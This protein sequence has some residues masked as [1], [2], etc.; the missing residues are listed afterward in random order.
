[1]KDKLSRCFAVAVFGALVLPFAYW[2]LFFDH[3]SQSWN[4]SCIHHS[5]SQSFNKSLKYISPALREFLN[6]ISAFGLPLTI[7]DLPWLQC[8]GG[9]SGIC[10]QLSL[11]RQFLFGTE[12]YKAFA[13]NITR[14]KPPLWQVSTT[15][16]RITVLIY[17]LRIGIVSVMHR[18][19][20]WLIPAVKEFNLPAYALKRYSVAAFNATSYLHVRYPYPLREFL[21]ELSEAEFIECQ[22][23]KAVA[24]R[25]QYASSNSSIPVINDT[26]IEQLAYFRDL[27]LSLHISPFLFGGTLLGWYRECGIIPHTTDLDMAAFISQFVPQLVSVLKNDQRLTL[28][29]M[30]GKPSDSLELSVFTK[31]TKTTKID[32]FFVYNDA[33]GS[34]V[35][36]MIPYER[37]KL[38]WTY[39]RISRLCKAELLNELFSVPCNVEEV[40]QA[41]YGSNWSIS[42]EE[43]NFLWYK[44]HKNVRTIG[45]YNTYEWM[46]VFRLFVRSKRNV[47]S[48][49]PPTVT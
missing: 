33:N 19:S 6:R 39:P 35:G 7:L 36:G 32:L 41:D 5:Y 15:A 16:A 31:S 47:S 2:N 27:L 43:R 17:N 49:S 45:K 14:I 3:C 1:M 12:A 11:R 13:E 28:Y 37:K 22:H 38:R 23:E 25:R 18:G 20:Y 30:L 34:W 24:I 26:A 42:V 9:V 46:N 29:W 40:L 48:R 8:I 10:E 21:S 4:Y 44:S